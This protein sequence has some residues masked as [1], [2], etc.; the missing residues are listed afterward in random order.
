M[1]IFIESRMGT[2]SPLSNY[3]MAPLSDC[4]LSN[5]PISSLPHCPADSLP[6][7]PL[8]PNVPCSLVR[9]SHQCPSVPVAQNP[10]FELSLCPSVRPSTVPASNCP[11]SK[12][13]SVPLSD[14]PRAHCSS[15]PSSH[16]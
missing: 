3:L 15:S 10:I 7:Y 4:P 8:R 1:N 2:H 11:M 16:G 5:C 9:L 13:S 14:C 6:H 12:L